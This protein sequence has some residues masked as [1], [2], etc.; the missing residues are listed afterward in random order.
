[1]EMNAL[2]LS[3][4]QLRLIEKFAKKITKTFRFRELDLMCIQDAEGL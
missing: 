4:I 3:A 2:L 1:M